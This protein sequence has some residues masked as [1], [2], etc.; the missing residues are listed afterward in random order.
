MN[1]DKE[2]IE[3]LKEFL[4]RKKQKL[5]FELTFSNELKLDLQEIKKDNSSLFKYILE[6]PKEILFNKNEIIEILPDYFK[7]KANYISFS[8]PEEEIKKIIKEFKPSL[9]KNDSLFGIQGRIKNIGPPLRV[10]LIM[11]VSCKQCGANHFRVPTN[12][13][14]RGTLRKGP[15]YILNCPCVKKGMMTRAKTEYVEWIPYQDLVLE[16]T[17]DRTLHNDN[18]KYIPYLRVFGQDIYKVR[19]GQE[20]FALV[21]P[22]LD[23]ESVS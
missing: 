5:L 1:L 13:L 12:P 16:T 22:F 6:N 17:S 2:K 4:K 3:E 8:L 23:F 20:V 21:N 9:L 15:R 11:N 14:T 19:Q 10:P 7:T 18:E